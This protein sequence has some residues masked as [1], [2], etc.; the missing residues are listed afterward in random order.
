MPRNIAYLPQIL[1]R[2]EKRT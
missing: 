1:K 2:S